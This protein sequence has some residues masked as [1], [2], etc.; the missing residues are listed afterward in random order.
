MKKNIF[1]TRI[2]SKTNSPIKAELDLDDLL[3]AKN[4][5]DA[6]FPVPEEGEKNVLVGSLSEHNILSMWYEITV[7]RICWENTSA[8]L[9]IM[10]DI[11]AL[12]EAE[13]TKDKLLATVSHDLRTPL[14][15][16]MGM[17]EY[18][19]DIDDIKE[20]KKLIKKALRSSN[21]L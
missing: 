11:T 8:V 14:S 17:L 16:I 7:S 9:I 18:A 20:S 4:Y 21:I 10:H 1:G 13:E 19:K 3:A 5:K 6:I 15:G 12:K 2:R